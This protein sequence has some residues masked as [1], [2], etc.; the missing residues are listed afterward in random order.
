MSSHFNY[1]NNHFPLLFNFLYFLHHSPYSCPG[2]NSMN[3]QL[4]L[5][6]PLF[7]PFSSSFFFHF[8][9]LVSIFFPS[10]FCYLGVIIMDGST[11]LSLSPR[12][13]LSFSFSLSC[14]FPLPSLFIPGH[15]TV[16][17]L[18]NQFKTGLQMLNVKRI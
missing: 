3:T 6:P 15:D 16:V 5:S 10:L 13:I 12:K 4:S 8:F 17:D 11:K 18:L 9:F 14:S 7:F 2:M 1:E